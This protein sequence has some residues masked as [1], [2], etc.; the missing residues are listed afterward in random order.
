MLSRV[1]E[2]EAMDTEQ[3]ALEY[4]AID[5]TEVNREFA[6]HALA[7]CS[8]AR[9]V[10]DLGTGTALIPIQMAL[11]NPAIEITAVDLA[12]QMLALARRNLAAVGLETRVRLE[13][14]DVKATGYETGQFDLLVCN[15]VVHHLPDPV[16]MFREI[17]RLMG[18]ETQILI[19]DLV[20]PNDAAG[21]KKLVETHAASDTPYQRKLFEDSLHAALSIPEVEAACHRAGLGPVDVVRVSDRHYC[22]TRRQ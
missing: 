21:L 20:R 8:N 18:R 22:I 10:L 13:V 6:R 19:K 7:V 9:R 14:R 17:A 12:G 4:D 15:S 11:L 16:P 3:D 1:L 5:H 2:P